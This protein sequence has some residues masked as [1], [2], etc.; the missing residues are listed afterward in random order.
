M[1]DDAKRISELTVVTSLSA[2]DRLVIL[3]NPSSSAQTQST[4]LTTLANT[5][6]SNTLI[7]IANTTQLGLVKT[8]A[9]NATNI[10]IVSNGS[11][12]VSVSGPYANDSAANSGGVSTNQL[13]Y[14][15]D[16][17]VKIRLA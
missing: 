3:T 7:P 13:Y 11:I 5:L 1:A 10:I 14:N 12:R 6:V 2:N 8:L 16:G 15:S 4:T 9:A 17:A